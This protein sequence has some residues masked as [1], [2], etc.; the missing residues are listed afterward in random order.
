MNALRPRAWP[1]GRPGGCTHLTGDLAIVV[2]VIQSEGPL[3]PAVLLHRHVTL[4]LLDTNR[5]QTDVAD[6]AVAG[7][8]VGHVMGLPPPPVLPRLCVKKRVMTTEPAS[9]NY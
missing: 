2:K 4:Q 5:Q 6:H 3:L 8:P 9:H 7:T 1:G